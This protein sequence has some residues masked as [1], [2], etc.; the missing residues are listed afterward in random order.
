MNQLQRQ[1]RPAELPTV[2]DTNRLGIDSD[3][4]NEPFL[5]LWFPAKGSDVWY[6]KYQH[7]YYPIVYA[8]LY[9]SWRMQS[10]QFVAGTKNKVEMGLMALGY[11]WLTSPTSVFFLAAGMAA[12]SL[13][14]SL[15]VPRHPEPGNETV[16]VRAAPAPAE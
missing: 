12:V 15:L 11:L 1:P 10:L 9:V 14:L 6:R 13:L 8:F 7:L 16:L 2:L 3:I 4:H 5:H